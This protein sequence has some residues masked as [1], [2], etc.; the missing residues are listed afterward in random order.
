MAYSVPKNEQQYRGLCA[1]AGVT[2]PWS[3]KTDILRTPL[4]VGGKIAPNRIAYQPMEGCDGT[5][6]GRPD[7]LYFK[8]H[9]YC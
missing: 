7:A 3:D 2:L 5:P 8:I 6:D 1:E 4:N 9:D